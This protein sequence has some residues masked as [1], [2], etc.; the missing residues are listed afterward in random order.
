LILFYEVDS[1]TADLSWA[2]DRH[3]ANTNKQNCV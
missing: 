2:P 1:P 3:P